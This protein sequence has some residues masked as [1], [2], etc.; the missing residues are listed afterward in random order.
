MIP[1]LKVVGIF[2]GGLLGVV[3]FFLVLLWL[4]WPRQPKT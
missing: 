4:F 3:L 1:L 2:V